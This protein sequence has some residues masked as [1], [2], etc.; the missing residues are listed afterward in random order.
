MAPIA[1][2][3]VIGTFALATGALHCVVP[4][5]TRSGCGRLNAPLVRRPGSLTLSVASP[6]LE[7]TVASLVAVYSRATP[8]WKGANVAGPLTASDS[9]A[10]TVPP[11]V[12]SVERSPSINVNVLKKISGNGSFGPCAAGLVHLVTKYRSCAPT[13]FFAGSRF[14]VSTR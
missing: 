11:T 4:S 12:P 10:G 7:V 1:C 6:A 2:L 13:G 3:N 9:V 14:A 5:S 8:G